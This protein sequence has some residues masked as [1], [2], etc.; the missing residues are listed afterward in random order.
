[1]KSVS[2]EKKVYIING[3]ENLNIAASN[4]ILK[5]L[6]EP[7]ENIIAILVCDNINN[8]L[9]TIISRCQVINLKLSSLL[10][11]NMLYNVANS[12]F[13]DDEK[14]NSKRVIS[15]SNIFATKILITCDKAIPIN[16]PN[17]NETSPIK[18]VSHNKIQEICRFPIPSII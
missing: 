16:K 1:M 14:I 9:E 4:S 18:K 3:V 15:A 10:S 12:F 5:F 17:P 6:E 8:V 11:D 13:N 2:S 7:E